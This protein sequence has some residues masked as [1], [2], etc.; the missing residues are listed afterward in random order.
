MGSIAILAPSVAVGQAAEL[1][2]GDRIRPGDVIRVQIW[3][4][5]TMSGEFPVSETG[6]VV[7]PKLGPRIVTDRVPGELRVELVEEY[8]KYLRNPSIDITF[9]KRITI[10]GAVREPGM[11]LID[12]T[13]TVAEAL[14]LAGGT[15]PDGATNRIELI[16]DAETLRTVT[17]RA[18]L[19]EIAIQSGDRL[20]VPER[21]WASRNPGVTAAVISG[22]ASLLVAL[23]IRS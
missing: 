12:P 20:Y 19:G 6:A 10:L 3:R 14:A 13:M 5:K 15:L 1:S 21:S 2:A 16:R 22:A 17:E 8:Q 4:E 18:R 9:L 11:A 23:I 7:L